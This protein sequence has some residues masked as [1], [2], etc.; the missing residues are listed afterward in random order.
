MR[1]RG[2]MTASRYDAVVVGGGPAG[3]TAALYLGRSRRRTLVVDSGSPRNIRAIEAHGVFTRDGT[4]PLDLLGEAR[5]QLGSYEEIDFRSG[6]AISAR[7]YKGQQGK[8]H[9]IVW[10]G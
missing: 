4:P 10:R 7:G 1:G 2:G 8:T 5:R 3:L 6:E 9:H